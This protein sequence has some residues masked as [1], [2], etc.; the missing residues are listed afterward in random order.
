M[1]ERHGGDKN[2]GRAPRRGSDGT[3][4]G[5]PI[6]PGRD[7]AVAAYGLR[8]AASAALVELG[9]TQAT[10]PPI[11]RATPTTRW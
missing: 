2:E 5:G 7:C 11:T 10:S 3:P 6:S 8:P 1:E 4:D 9:A